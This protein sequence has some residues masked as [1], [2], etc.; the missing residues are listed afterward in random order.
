MSAA[1]IR[2]NFAHTVPTEPNIRAACRNTSFEYTS[3]TM[4]DTLNIFDFSITISIA[5]SKSFKR[6]FDSK[7]I[8]FCVTNKFLPDSRKCYVR[9]T[10]VFYISDDLKIVGCDNRGAAASFV[11]IVGT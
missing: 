11:Y 10:R 3:R 8:F 1:K 9:F 4:C 7:K 2:P 6:Y 5:L